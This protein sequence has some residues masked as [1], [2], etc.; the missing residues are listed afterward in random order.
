MSTQGRLQ[1]RFPG[2][3][4]LIPLSVFDDE[5]FQSAIVDAISKMSHQEVAEMK[6]KVKKAGERHIE[7]RDTTDPSIVTDLLATI[8]SSVGDSILAPALV[9]KT[10]EQVCWK[11]AKVPWRRSPLWLL[12]R[13]TIQT[14]MSRANEESLY[15]Q[16]MIFLMASILKATDALPVSSEVLYCMVAKISGRL[17]KLR[18]DSQYSWFESVGNVLTS[19]ALRI[20]VDWKEINRVLDSDLQFEPISAAWL[21]RDSYSLCPALQEFIESIESRQP[22]VAGATFRPSWSV[23]E[24]DSL[25]LPSLAFLQRDESMTFGLLAFEHWVAVSL[26]SWLKG[27]IDTAGTPDNLLR[28]METYH[29]ASLRCYSES[30]DAI[31]LMVLTVMEMWV[32]CDRSAC[33]QNALLLDYDHEIPGELLQS[34]ILPF[35]NDM[36]RLHHVEVYLKDRHDRALQTQTPSIF[37]SFGNPRSFGVRFFASSEYHQTLLQKVKDEAERDIELK[38]EEFARKKDIY[39]LHMAKHSALAHEYCD[40]V[41]RRTGVIT[42]V[43]SNSCQSCHH[44]NFA[45]NQKIEVHEWPLPKVTHQAHNVVFEMQ[46]PDFFRGWRDATAHVITAV[47]H[48]SSSTAAQPEDYLANYFAHNHGWTKS[49]GRFVLASTTKSN[50]RTHRK[51][52]RLATASESDILVK[53][54]LSFRYYDNTTRSWMSGFEKTDRIPALCTYQLSNSCISLQ[55]FIFR[56]SHQPNGLSANHIISQQSKCPEHLSVDEFKAMAVLPCGFRLQW[57]NMLTQ[58]HMPAVDFTKSDVLQILLQVSR[59]AGPTGVSGKFRPGHQILSDDKFTSAFLDGLELSLRRVKENWETYHA[60]SGFIAL[61]ARVLSLSPSAEVSS[62]CLLFLEEC[63]VVAM[64]W[65]ALLQEKLKQSENDN[66]RTEFLS[67]LLQVAQTCAESFDLDEKHLQSLLSTPSSAAVL[68]ESSIVAQNASHSAPDSRNL[69]RA[70]GLRRILHKTYKFLR[71]RLWLE[72]ILVLT[73]PC[74]RAG[75]HTPDTRAAV[76]GNGSQSHMAIGWLGPQPTKARLCL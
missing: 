9:K 44:K 46:V 8:L 37:T 25:S 50:R 56:P 61:S 74:P 72:T 41:N 35:K 7:E 64:S 36:Q 14:I 75:L 20:E 53:N 63:R 65:L 76:N 4:V 54:G 29:E 22:I 33:S 11:D 21:R 40:K 38:K 23:P 60:L 57:L 15:K 42:T 67:R 68:I 13:V 6:P 52:K 12:V 5:D 66:T 28:L 2:S 26:D 47:L 10:R 51:A 31:S 17:Q 48:S 71:K 59:Q 39:Q 27:N 43:H 1:R 19:A 16:F 73:L 18:K 34:L 24:W 58:L 30:P 49:S 62:R 45:E 70:N 32:A 69:V 3:A 55:S